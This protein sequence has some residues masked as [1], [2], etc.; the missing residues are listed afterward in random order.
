MKYYSMHHRGGLS[1]ALETKERISESEFR[2]LFVKYN[3]IPYCYDKRISCYR[4]IISNME[5]NFKQP[6]WLLLEEEKR[7]DNDD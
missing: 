4:F 2:R 3:Y 5:I 1:E 7:N 6:T